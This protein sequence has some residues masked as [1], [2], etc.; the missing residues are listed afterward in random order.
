MMANKCC[1]IEEVDMKKCLA[2][3]LVLMALDSNSASARLLDGNALYKLCT[4]T[5]QDPSRFQKLSQ[6]QGY[7]NGVSDAEE[8]FVQLNVTPRTVC[9]GHGVKSGQIKDVTVKYLAGHP[10]WRRLNAASAVLKAL[11]DAFPCAR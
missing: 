11:E 5:D 6:C 7:V 8:N 10:Q 1:A 3:L 2:A 9:Y 4:T